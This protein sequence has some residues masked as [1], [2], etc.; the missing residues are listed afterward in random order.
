MLR[1]ADSV[2]RG[3]A[4]E[5]DELSFF[6]RLDS[7]QEQYDRVWQAYLTETSEDGMASEQVQE[8]MNK[9][10]YRYF[11][12]S[13][14]LY[15]K[16]RLLRGEAPTMIGFGKENVESATTYFAQNLQRKSEDLDWLY[17]IA[18]DD[19]KQALAIST[20]AA[21]AVNLKQGFW[22]EGLH[23]LLD[24]ATLDT[25]A[26]HQAMA[27]AMLI[28]AL[29]DLRLDFY[30]DIGERW[31]ELVKQKEEVA[32]ASIEALAGQ[33]EASEQL[34]ETWIFSLVCDT[35]EK[36]CRIAHEYL[37]KEMNE[38]AFD[39][40]LMNRSDMCGT[41]DVLRADMLLY[42]DLWD[43][44]LGIYQ[45][46]VERGEDTPHV[47][48]HLAWCALLTGN[49]SLAEQ[50]MIRRLRDAKNVRKEDY[51][52]YGHLCWLKGDRVTAYENY[53][54]ARRL[55]KDLKEWK[56]TFCPDRK[57]IS[58]LGIPLEEVYLMEDRLLKL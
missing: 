35:D 22:E 13:D 52:N 26:A 6:A 57:I 21:L 17:E 1:H 16:L 40:C 41:D 55:C 39:G 10:T 56:A 32:I 8:A 34:P 42:D 46:I 4:K 36:R 20:I 3:W 43:E 30:Q 47:R 9:L 51:I 44:A 53:R 28:T 12:L 29:Y 49:Y 33:S 14:E 24:I 18:Q 5:V 54:E 48:F 45:D 7:L 31:V 27:Q 15:D 25:L 11:Q 2:L 37:R 58:Q 23:L 50:Y 19:D 38:Q